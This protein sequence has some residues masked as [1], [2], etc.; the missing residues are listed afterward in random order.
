[1]SERTVDGGSGATHQEAAPG[2]DPGATHRE[3]AGGGR[4]TVGHASLFPDELAGSYRRVDAMP[5]IGGEALLFE[6]ETSGGDNR[7]LKVYHPH[8]RLRVDA[9]RRVQD[10]DRAHVV[11]L[12][13][14]GQLSDGR[15]FEVQERLAGGNLVEF[16]RRQGAT[17]SDETVRLIVAQVS[18]AIA[19]FHAAGLAHHDIKPENVLVRSDTPLDLVL[20]DFGLAVVADRKTYYATNRNA[21]IAYQAPETLLQIGGPPRDYWAL[22]LT[23]AMAATGNPPYDGQG[24]HAIYKQHTAQIPPQIIEDMPDGRL[25]QLCRGLTRYDPKKRW[26]IDEVRRWLAGEDPAVA[27]DKPAAGVTAGGVGFNQRVF[28]SASELAAELVSSWELAAQILGVSGTREPFLHKVMVEFSSDALG[29]LSQRWETNPPKRQFVNEAIVDLVAALDP[30]HD[31]WFQDRPLTPDT[32]AAAALGDSEE[33]RLVVEVL[34]NE[35]ILEAWGQSPRHGELGEIDRRWR[36]ALRRADEIISAVES[37][38]DHMVYPKVDVPALDDWAGP[39]LAICAREELLADW[40]RRHLQ[41][42]PEGRHV[43]QWYEDLAKRSTAADTVAGVLLADEAARVQQDE[44]ERQRRRQALEDQR[45]KQ[46]RSRGLNIKLAWISG[47][48]YLGARVLESL[49]YESAFLSYP[50]TASALLILSLLAAVGWL[51]SEDKTFFGWFSLVAFA[52]FGLVMWFFDDWMF[53]IEYPPWVLAIALLG[54]WKTPVDDARNQRRAERCSLGA[55]VA[56]AYWYV[57]GAYR[58]VVGLPDGGNAAIAA[59]AI[60]AYGLSAATALWRATLS[61]KSRRRAQAGATVLRGDG[62]LP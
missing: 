58:G 15:W 11:E 43:P 9:L 8:V 56:I 22:G 20:S 45:R 48:L 6:V 46:E 51:S 21:T 12:L 24:D 61:F 4:T 26:K 38:Y 57:I 32:I 35:G 25:K 39:L 30:D 28:L 13:E 29:E 53:R 42:R 37:A 50:N 7:V 2:G 16:L 41:K 49:V 18:E 23:V 27:A 44:A 31:A 14:F 62:P 40:E 3:A 17:P 52:G 34:R 1:M 59:W 47:L 33:D 10:L 60:R 19:A 54:Q 36:D 5:P 55:F